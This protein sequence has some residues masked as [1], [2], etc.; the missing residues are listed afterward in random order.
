M[1]PFGWG[2]DVGEHITCDIQGA[3]TMSILMLIFAAQPRKGR[4]SPI[5][6]RSCRAP[7]QGSVELVA[8]FAAE[9]PF[10]FRYPAV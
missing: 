4:F 5:R 1:V 2:L 6:T 8:Y 7:R 3:L 9:R 10:A